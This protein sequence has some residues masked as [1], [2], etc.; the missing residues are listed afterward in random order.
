MKKSTL[1]WVI[2]FCAF[3]LRLV[4]VLYAL[5]YRE[6][7]DILR[8]KD[9]ARTAFL[10]SYADTYTQKYLTF[11]TL[12]NNQPPGSLY[13]LSAFYDIN[14]LFAKIVLRFAPHTPVVYAWLSV[15]AL[16]FMLRLPSIFADC[17]IGLGVWLYFGSQKFQA[18]N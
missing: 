10:H 9:W 12:P 6:N 7:T 5:Q 1:L 18:F 2:I 16:D 11:G 15:P 13:I 4:L 14:I 8:Y 3:V 17:L